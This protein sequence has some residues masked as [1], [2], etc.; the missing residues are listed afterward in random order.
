[1]AIR[2][3]RLSSLR[4]LA[5][6]GIFVTILTNMRSALELHFLGSD[7]HFMAITALD[8]A[9]GAEQ[10]EF[11]FRMVE[12]VDVSPGPYVMAGFAAQGRAVRAALRHAL[13]ELAVMRIVVACRTAQI[14]EMEG[15]DFIGAARSAYLMT[16][17]ARHGCVSASQGETCVAM[18]G[19]SKS[20]TMK[21]QDGVTALAFIQIRLGCK[22]IV[23]SIFMAIRASRE[24]HLVNRV[25]TCGKMAF[26]AFDCDVL[27]LQRVIGSVV[28]LHT[29]E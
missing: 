28:F 22:L 19:D 24:F 27:A 20:G 2:A 4:K 12:A 23:V 8:G 11:R 9:V 29:E 5:C 16:I 14:L 26:A 6:V 25:F 18:F 7:R 13:L 3:S 10:R 1:M 15:Q 21:V 17:G